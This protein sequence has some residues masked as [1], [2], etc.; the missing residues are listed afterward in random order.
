MVDSNLVDTPTIYKEKLLIDST[1]TKVDV[2]VYKS[3][4]GSIMFLSNTG[5]DLVYVVGVLSRFMHSPY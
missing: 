4:I 1:V 5:L 2:Y 3:I